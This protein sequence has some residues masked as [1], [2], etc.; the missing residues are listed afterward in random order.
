MRNTQILIKIS[1]SWHS[2]R[3]AHLTIKWLLQQ[4]C[5]RGSWE[6]T[7][8]TS[9]ITG[10]FFFVIL[11]KWKCRYFLNFSSYIWMWRRGTRCFSSEIELNPEALSNRLRE[12]L[13]SVNIQTLFPTHSVTTKM[14]VIRADWIRLWPLEG[15]LTETFGLA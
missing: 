9:E 1:L 13:I 4:L 11:V 2:D 14:T 15:N 7:V 10:C 3:Y 6:R 5:S 8:N 12:S